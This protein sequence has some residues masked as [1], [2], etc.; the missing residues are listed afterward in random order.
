MRLDSFLFENKYFDSRNKA[1]ES[2]E[3]GEV[4]IDNVC[5]KKP[6][7]NIRGNE[8][9][10]IVQPKEFVSIGGYKIDKAISTFN[11]DAKGCVCVD[12]GSSTGG[13][14]DSLLQNGAKKVYA[15]DV[16]VDILHEKLKNDNRVVS[17]K[18]NAKE[19]TKEDLCNEKIDI[20]VVD[21]S[22][23]SAQHVSKPIYDILDDFGTLILLCKPQFE[24]DIFSYHKNGIIKDIKERKN[25]CEKVCNSLISAG[26][27]VKNI[28]SAP[29]VNGKNVEYLIL[30]DKQKEN[31]F[32]F[33]KIDFNTL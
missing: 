31:I 14:T 24:S 21:L 13:F 2:V 30:A 23:I 11:I 33:D 1:K 22:F 17:V 28:T 20:V 6:S 26:F 15:V 25:A 7:F 29:K 9:I 12:I 4:F 8:E 19:L 10:K 5:Q 27:Y 16:N 18:R 3:R 32:C